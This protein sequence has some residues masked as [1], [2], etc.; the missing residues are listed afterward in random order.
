MVDDT[1]SEAL[2]TLC[3]HDTATYFLQSHCFQETETWYYFAENLPSDASSVKD[4]T[5]FSM[6][7]FHGVNELQRLL[8]IHHSQLC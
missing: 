4:L 2:Q 3:V 8:Q 1:D 5:A 7:L 6:D